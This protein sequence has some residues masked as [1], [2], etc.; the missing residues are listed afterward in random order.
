MVDTNRRAVLLGSVAGVLFGLFGVLISQTADTSGVW[1]LVG[2]RVASIPTMAAI[3]LV[4]GKPLLVVRATAM[5][6]SATAG[7]AD[8]IAN[9]L[10]LAALH[11][12][13]LLS[14]VLL[15]S[16][17]YP[18]GTVLLARVVLDERINRVQIGGLIMAGFGLALHRGRLIDR[19]VARMDR[20][21]K[22]P[23]TDVLIIGGGIVGLATARSLH[24]QDPSLDITVIEKESA[25]GSH[26]TGNNSGVLHSG[27]Y[28][29][30]GSLKARS[31]H[32]GS[33]A[34]GRVLPG[35]RACRSGSPGSWWWRPP[36]RRSPVWRT[37]H[38]R[39][40]ANGVEGIERLGPEGIADHEPHAVG[41]AALWV[42]GT[43]VV[44]FSA[45]AQR[46]GEDLVTGGVE[47]VTGCEVDAID[48]SAAGRGSG[49]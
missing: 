25:L 18:A 33:P 47:V 32:R 10:L 23:N 34:D 1:P 20:V 29:R 9:I 12:P 42:P 24:D 8:M 40:V 30:P 15:I 39:G 2:A 28:Y 36:P 41:L 5:R 6:I 43:G 37:L 11:E 7:A 44:D 14:L 21:T 17:L 4:M 49:R 38:A 27:L 3:A 46:M 31:V 26:Q 19:A 45:I 13:G 48:T 22:P 16:S 35:A